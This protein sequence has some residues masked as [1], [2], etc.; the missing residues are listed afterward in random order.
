MFAKLTWI[1]GE[2]CVG[3][4]FDNIYLGVFVLMHMLVLLMTKHRYIYARTT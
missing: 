2:R 3:V 1:L 4:R